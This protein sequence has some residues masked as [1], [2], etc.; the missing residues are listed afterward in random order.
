MNCEVAE[1][2]G[3]AAAQVL[4]VCAAEVRALYDGKID[5]TVLEVAT[6]D[7]AR[8]WRVGQKCYLDDPSFGEV[9]ALDDLRFDHLLGLFSIH[10]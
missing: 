2:A 6:Q 5:S 10:W 3:V 9:V 8:Y 7:P 1:L 4:E